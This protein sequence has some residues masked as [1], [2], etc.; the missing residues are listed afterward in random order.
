M[1]GARGTSSGQPDESEQR[2]AET[3][4][5]G[6]GGP[7]GPAGPQPGLQNWSP[8]EPGAT[9]RSKGCTVCGVD[10][11]SRRTGVQAGRSAKGT[12]DE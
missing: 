4:T 7:Q 8:R 11:S 1:R 12:E 10:N 6:A 9:G 2:A 3:S 5:R